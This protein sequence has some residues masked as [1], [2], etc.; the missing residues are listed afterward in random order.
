MTHQLITVDKYAEAE[1]IIKEQVYDILNELSQHGIPKE[2][3]KG[4][5]GVH[6]LL[7]SCIT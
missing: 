6:A 4:D 1:L 2:Y 5:T 3:R 7:V